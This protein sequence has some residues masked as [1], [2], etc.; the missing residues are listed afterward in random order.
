LTCDPLLGKKFYE[1]STPIGGTLAQLDVMPMSSAV[2]TVEF[3]EF[4]ENAT[5]SDLD[6]CGSLIALPITVN[7]GGLGVTPTFDFMTRLL[8]IP[9]NVPTAKAG[10]TYDVTV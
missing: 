7:N 10:V 6:K 3:D 1:T 2:T 4:R 8:T 5:L 9:A